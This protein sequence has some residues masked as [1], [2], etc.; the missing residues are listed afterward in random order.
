MRIVSYDFA[1]IAAMMRTSEYR[2]RMTDSV[3][4][5]RTLAC[6]RDVTWTQ[7][8]SNV[9]F[10][11]CELTISYISMRTGSPKWWIDWYNGFRCENLPASCVYVSAEADGGSLCQRDT[12][13]EIYPVSFLA[14]SVPYGPE[15]NS[16]PSYYRRRKTDGTATSIARRI[17]STAETCSASPRSKHG[18][19]TIPFF[20]QIWMAPRR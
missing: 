5:V 4:I 14:S 16:R 12:G 17:G 18:E 2:R 10:L 1:A 15:Q 9:F 13:M 19:D 6:V 11:A 7:L 20:P 8:T 3:E